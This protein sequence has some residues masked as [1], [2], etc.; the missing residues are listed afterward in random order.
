MKKIILL[1]DNNQQALE[2]DYYTMRL[3]KE[4]IKTEFAGADFYS[5]DI[6]DFEG[7]IVPAERFFET[8][9][10]SGVK[11]DLI[12]RIY[13]SGKFVAAV[14]SFGWMIIKD[15]SFQFAINKNA[16]YSNDPENPYSLPYFCSQLIRFIKKSRPVK[17]SF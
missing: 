9:R 14:N 1:V 16:S 10:L 12:S 17:I 8:Q 7:I 15:S 13:K 5:G 11:N 4:N 6:S 3:R 2:A